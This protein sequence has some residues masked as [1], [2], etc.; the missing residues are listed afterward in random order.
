MTPSRGWYPDIRAVRLSGQT[1]LSV[2]RVVLDRATSR[3]IR[4]YGP[5]VNRLARRKYGISGKQLLSRLVAG[6]S[7]G[8]ADAVSGAGARGKTQFM[9]ETRQAMIEQFGVD[10]WRSTDEAVKGAVIH[11]QGKL[12]HAKGLEG[13]NPGGGQQYVSYILG[14]RAKLSGKG[15]RAPTRTEGMGNAQAPGLLTAPTGLA[16]KLQ[17]PESVPMRS[18]GIQTPEF[19]ARPVV[20]EGYRAPPSGGGPAPRLAE[21]MQAAVP[22][23]SLVEAVQQGEQAG[24]GQAGR[25]GGRVRGSGGYP[26]AKRGKVIGTPGQGT[27]TLGNWQSDQAY[28]F[29]APVGTR[30]LAT[31]AGVV[32]KVGGAWKGGADRFDG[33]QVTIQ[34][35]NGGVFYTHMKSANVKVGQKVKRGSVLGRSGAANGVP[36]LHIG[37]ENLKGRRL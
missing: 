34:G 25:G 28:D 36:H 26:L 12:G 21:T 29:A 30:V 4:R 1:S 22:A 6:E 11:L 13:Y 37:F 35:K 2:S 18:A 27:H 9:P 33:F 3:A 5:D 20:P 23:P 19:A 24:G 31:D 7:G 14:Q 16:S 8:R 17:A 10:P 32:V 15:G